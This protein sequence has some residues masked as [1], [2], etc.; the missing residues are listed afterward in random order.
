MLLDE[1]LNA[2]NHLVNQSY[3][4]DKSCLGKLSAASSSECQSHYGCASD[5]NR[6]LRPKARDSRRLLNCEELTQYSTSVQP[7]MVMH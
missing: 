1:L 7:S 3:Q 6:H 5:L 4:S 2:F